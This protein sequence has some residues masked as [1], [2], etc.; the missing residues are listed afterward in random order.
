M[1]RESSGRGKKAHSRC[2]HQGN[3]EA[4]SEEGGLGPGC[5]RRAI[6]SH[7]KI[8]AVR[9]QGPA[10]P[11]DARLLASQMWRNPGCGRFLRREGRTGFPDPGVN[12]S[13]QASAWEQKEV[14]L[15]H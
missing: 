2:S 8:H 14:G 5:K 15:M 9:K 3:T 10:N 6:P 4:L 13:A 11:N 7:G 12:A 1:L